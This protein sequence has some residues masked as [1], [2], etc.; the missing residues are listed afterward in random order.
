MLLRILFGFI[1]FARGSEDQACYTNVV[2]NGYQPFLR[3][4]ILNVLNTYKGANSILLDY[5]SHLQSIS[6][7]VESYKFKEVSEW[8]WYAWMGFYIELQKQLDNGYWDYVAN[9]AGGFLGFWWYFQGDTDCEQYL[10]LEKDKFC[11][12]IRVKNSNERARLRSKWYKNIEK[13]GSK[14]GLDLTKPARFGNGKHMTVCVLEGDYRKT[15]K[16]MLNV[17]ETIKQLRNAERLLQS[18]N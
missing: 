1:S 4:E 2:K 5:R 17:Q 16:G 8:G 9:P 14:Y 15:K 12:K 3:T 11:F 7:K 6:D 10:Q 13:H 18:I